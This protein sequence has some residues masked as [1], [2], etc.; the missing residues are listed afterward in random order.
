MNSFLVSVVIPVYNAER[1]IEEA[2]VSA[3]SQQEVGEVILIEDGS[4]DESLRKCQELSN[5][6]D[7]VILLWH[8]KHAN[9]GAGFSRNLGIKNAQYDYISFLDADDYYLP[10]RFNNERRL[11]LD[12]PGLGGVYAATGFVFESEIARSN[13]SEFREEATLT[14]TDKKLEGP[15]LF[16]ALLFGGHGH[17]STDAIVFRKTAIDLIGFFE[18][19]ENGE[20]THFFLKL[21]LMVNVVP[22]EI[23]EPVAI[24]RVHENSRCIIDTK[25]AKNAR[26]R[27]YKDL[28]QWSLNNTGVSFDR[29]N[30][31]FQALTNQYLSN[32][33]F[34]VLLIL[35]YELPLSI[36][37]SF[38]WLKMISL[39]RRLFVSS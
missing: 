5:S 25:K 23:A 36:I 12:N 35:A 15:E 21:C 22:G 6:H 8:D 30:D 18:N 28:Y 24:R 14:T 7:N 27:I 39:M 33:Q 26:K 32:N 13:W 37:S 20:D 31:I 10:N 29:K 16:K 1:F 34:I 9:R 3:L 2:V 11:F 4:K 19:Y 17:F 38:T